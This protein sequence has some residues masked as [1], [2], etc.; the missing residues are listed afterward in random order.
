VR[1]YK[2]NVRIGLYGSIGWSNTLH[3]RS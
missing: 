2:G 3:I 1:S